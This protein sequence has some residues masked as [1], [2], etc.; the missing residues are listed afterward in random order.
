MRIETVE[1]EI[2]SSGVE[3]YAELSR[4]I[5]IGP[6]GKLLVIDGDGRTAILIERTE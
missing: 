6:D 3:R 4:G 1:P 5:Y 2:M